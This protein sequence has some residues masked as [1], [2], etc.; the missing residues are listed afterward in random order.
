MQVCSDYFLVALDYKVP[1]FKLDNFCSYCSWP[2]LYFKNMK[3]IFHGLK[4]KGGL[5]LSN[6]VRFP[7]I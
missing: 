6:L 1:A 5:Y 4:L 2:I 3:M 7:L